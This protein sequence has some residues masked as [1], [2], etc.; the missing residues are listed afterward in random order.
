[1]KKS[2]VGTWSVI[3]A[4]NREYECVF[5][6]NMPI[7]GKNFDTDKFFNLGYKIGHYLWQVERESLI[8]GRGETDRKVKKN[9]K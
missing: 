5:I 9:R 2:P 3:I 8:K 1:M 6:S 4:P 7:E